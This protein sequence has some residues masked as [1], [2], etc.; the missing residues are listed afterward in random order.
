MSEALAEQAKATNNKTDSLL[1]KFSTWTP[2]MQSM[3][4]SVTDLN[5]AAATL[6]LHTED[7][8]ARLAALESHPPPLAPSLPVDVIPL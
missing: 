6:R 5:M 3:E 7:T 2:W 1:D 8:A 4:A